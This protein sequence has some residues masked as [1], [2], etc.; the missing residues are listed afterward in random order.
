MEPASKLVYFTIHDDA[1]T[2]TRSH[3]F[4]LF[5][6]GFTRS[7]T[8]SANGRPCFH[9]SHGIVRRVCVLCNLRLRR[10]RRHP[11]DER[12]V[13]V[14]ARLHGVRGVLLAVEVQ[15]D[16]LILNPALPRVDTRQRG[17]APSTRERRRRLFRCEPHSSTS[18]TLVCCLLSYLF[19]FLFFFVI[20]FPTKYTRHRHRAYLN[21]PLFTR[22]NPSVVHI[23]RS[24]NQVKMRRAYTSLQE[25][26]ASRECTLYVW[27]CGMANVR[28]LA[29]DTASS[30]TTGCH[31]LPNNPLPGCVSVDDAC[32]PPR[33][34]P[35]P[36]N[37]ATQTR[38]A[39]R[40]DCA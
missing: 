35:D 8:C 20:I 33:L 22:L 10:R 39:A 40:A 15:P 24:H 34:T 36:P 16:V 5:C 14:E 13:G 38:E 31:A 25:I 26:V 29:C 6:H 3:L 4:G 11:G 9:L 17:S 27:V 12:D 7:R 30:T 23:Y 18:T 19:L 21:L 2:R 1:K 32:R 28:H 37:P